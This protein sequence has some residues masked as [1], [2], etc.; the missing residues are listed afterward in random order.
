MS[1]LRRFKLAGAAAIAALL[2]SGCVPAAG[3]GTGGGETDAAG[4]PQPGGTLIWGSRSEPGNGGLDPYIAAVYRSTAYLAQTYETLIVRDDAGEF[5]PALATE[6]EQVDDLTYRFTIR[7]GVKFADGTDLTVDDVLWS[8]NH[9][10][11]VEGDGD[12]ALAKLVS[13]EEVEDGVIEFVFSEPNPGF[14]NTISRRTGSYFV[15]DQ[16]WYEAAD[17]TTRQTTTNGTGPFTVESWV[18]GTELKLVKNEHY[19][20][21]GV[22]YLDG[23]TFKITN[24]DEGALLALVQQNQ[25]DAAWFWSQEL[26]AQAETSGFTLGDPAQTSARSIWIDPTF[27]DGALGDVRVRQAISLAI[28]RDA[29]IELGTNGIGAPTFV[30]PPAH[31]DLAAPDAET[32]NYQHDPERAKQL[33]KDAGVENLEIAITYGDD[34]SDVASLELIAQQ[35]SEVGITLRLN[36]VPYAEVQN[37]FTTGADYPSELVYVVGTRSPD[38]ATAFHEWLNDAGLV[39]HWQGHPDAA[40]AKELLAEITRNPDLDE[41]VKQIDELNRIVA[42]NVLILTPY[43]TPLAYHLWSD[44][45]H[46]YQT[47]QEDGRSL[48]KYTWLSGQE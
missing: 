10:R 26:A 33:L 42:E 14:L 38:P 6:W 34:T 27:N 47:D 44:K 12:V 9:H 36:P 41:R 13:L 37:V 48:L 17:E 43:A 3:T 24:G 2:L 4:E 15:V 7:D 40:E 19:W 25:V 8:F 39:S 46:G 31:T 30:T 35:L 28:D 21:E 23:I 18:Q 5:H 20:E 1:K 16:Q 29:V 45:V 11:E 22:P 32:P